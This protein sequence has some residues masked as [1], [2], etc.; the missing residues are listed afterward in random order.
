MAADRSDP[1]SIA[2]QPIADAELPGIF[3]ALRPNRTIALAVSGGTDS[4]ALAVLAARWRRHFAPAVKLLAYV[5]DHGLRDGSHEDALNACAMAHSWGIESRLLRR[6][7]PAPESGIQ[8]RARLARYDLMAAQALI[9]ST[10]VLLTAHNAGDQAETVLMRA[11]RGEPDGEL[12]GIPQWGEWS[13]LALHRPLLSIGRERLAATLAAM[14]LNPIEDPSNDD[15]KFE[16]VRMRK[17]LA[18]QPNPR[19]ARDS[20]C[21]LT[22]I[23][24]EKHAHLADQAAGLFNR[25]GTYH[26]QGFVTLESDALFESFG[27]L[28]VLLSA[29]LHRIGGQVRPPHR[30]QVVRLAEQLADVD[31]SHRVRSTLARA[32]VV[33]RDGRLHVFREI[34][35]NQA[36]FIT[37]TQRVPAVFDRR[38]RVLAKQDC[39]VGYATDSH[40]EDMSTELVANDVPKVIARAVAGGFPTGF[41]AENAELAVRPLPMYFGRHQVHAP[42]EIGLSQSASTARVIA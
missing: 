14:G 39:M 34:G 19:L 5:V 9:D 24:A 38:F 3:G 12:Q 13:G 27:G 42:L 23:A 10:A 25:H 29:V 4:L 8:A 31:S 16:R 6:E 18:S 7:G 20:L 36:D 15:S 22:E 28:C 30:E 41:G 35:R 2:P 37:L 32:R 1:G 33:M 21:R 17:L 26:P 11:R 40:L